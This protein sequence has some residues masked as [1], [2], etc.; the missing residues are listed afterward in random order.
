VVGG[1]LEYKLTQQV[2][3]GVEGLYYA[4]DKGGLGQSFDSDVFSVRG[5]LTFHLDKGGAGSYKDAIPGVSMANWAGFYAGGHAGA[6]FDAASNTIKS[7]RS[8]NGDSGAGGTDGTG[9]DVGGGGGGGGGGAIAAA[10]LDNSASFAGGGQIGYNWQ[11]GAWVYGLESD[12]TFGDSAQHHLLATGRGRLG[13]ANGALLFYGTGGVAYANAERYR[14]VVAGNGANGQKGGDSI[15]QGGNG[16]GG[17]GGAGGAAY[18]LKTNEDK[19]GYVVGG[20]IDAKI[21]NNVVIGFEGLYYGFDNKSG[22]SAG[23][24][25]ATSFT[26]A[27]SADEFVVRSRLSY[28]FSPYHDPLK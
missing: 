24:A 18:A 28:Q 26:G 11:N 10:S 13:Y 27:D 3:L 12:L 9:V 15:E 21:T 22:S 25:N 17:D 1:G 8:R 20:G 5:R 16:W 7:V 19:V 2:G 14:A 6:A 23:T 4:F